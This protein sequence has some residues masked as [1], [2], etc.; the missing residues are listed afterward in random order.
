MSLYRRDLQVPD[1]HYAVDDTDGELTYWAVR[2]G[3]WQDY[4]PGARWRPLPP[5]PKERLSR[6]EHRQRMTD[7]Y[8]TE[9]ADYCAHIADATEA[10]PVGARQRFV[11]RY[12]H[13][14]LPEPPRPKKPRQQPNRAAGGRPPP[15][16][17]VGPGGAGT[18]Q[19]GG[20]GGGA[21]ARW[22]VV[23]AHRAHLGLLTTDGLAPGC[24]G[25]AS[26]A[27][28]RLPAVDDSSV[29]VLARRGR[30]ADPGR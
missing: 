29:A 10:D 26:D 9:Y 19:A 21:A 2:A 16:R 7:W 20:H 4:P 22:H 11:D 25:P 5:R 27:L 14:P 1:G 23:P 28:A 3:R 30:Q 18:P 13:R 24:A 15:R 12:G 17:P 6:D 8:E